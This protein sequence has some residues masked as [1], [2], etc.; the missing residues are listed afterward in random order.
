MQ[1]ILLYYKFIP[2]ADPADAVRLWQKTCAK[3]EPAWSDP[4]LDKGLNGTL[5]VTS[6]ILKHIQRNKSDARSKTY[7]SKERRR[8]RGFP[9]L[10]IKVR[11]GDGMN[12]VVEQYL[13]HLFS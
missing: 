10:S 3:A 4:N 1:K 5:A 9:K 7:Y 11:S 8:P 12:L 6:Q 2:I 13:L